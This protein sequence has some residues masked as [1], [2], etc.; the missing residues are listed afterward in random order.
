MTAQLT[1][2]GSLVLSWFALIPR[3]CHRHIA[4]PS[5]PRPGRLLVSR[6]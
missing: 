3:P 4:R 6:G 1:W 5:P 2:L